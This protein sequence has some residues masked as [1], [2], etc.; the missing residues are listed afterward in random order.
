MID[1]AITAIAA[2]MIEHSYATGHGDTVDGMLVELEAQAIRRGA[3]RIAL[4]IT[5]DMAVLAM[6]HV[7]GCN[8]DDM[9]S[10]LEAALGL[11]SSAS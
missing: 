7:P 6:A 5:D 3:S 4:G 10:A 9:V 8:H 11:P 1:P 2:W